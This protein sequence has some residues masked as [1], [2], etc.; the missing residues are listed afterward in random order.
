MVAP[1]AAEAHNGEVREAFTTVA[2]I[3]HPHLSTRLLFSL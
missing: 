3:F 2:G 1:P